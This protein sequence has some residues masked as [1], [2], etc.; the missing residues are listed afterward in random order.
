MDTIDILEALKT[1]YGRAASKA[2]RQFGHDKEMFGYYAGI[3]DFCKHFGACLELG[4]TTGADHLFDGVRPGLAQDDGPAIVMGIDIRRIQEYLDTLLPEDWDRMDLKA[5][6]KFFRRPGKVKG[7]VRRDRVCARELLCEVFNE[8]P[9]DLTPGVVR[10]MEKILASLRG[11]K[12]HAKG[13]GRLKFPIYGVQRAFLR[14]TPG[15]MLDE[16]ALWVRLKSGVAWAGGSLD[17][18]A[19]EEPGDPIWAVRLPGRTVLVEFRAPTR[20][21]TALQEERLGELRRAGFEVL[22]LDSLRAVDRFVESLKKEA[23]QRARTGD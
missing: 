23:A 22:V 1:Y 16:R 9:Q 15:E 20:E 13:S 4:I 2:E 6:R 10:S 7:T 12:P 11:W 18:W 3:R 8:D 5:R 17:P 21:L 14:R 19:G